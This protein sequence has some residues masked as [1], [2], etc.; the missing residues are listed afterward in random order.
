MNLPTRLP[1]FPLGSVLLPGA[2]MPL[3]IFE[4]RYRVLM[5]DRSGQDPIF[6]VVL[7]E[8]GHEVGDRPTI[9]TV[10]TAATLLAGNEFPDGRWAILIEGGRRFR[11]LGS[12]WERSYLVGSIEWLADE[13]RDVSIPPTAAGQLIG[14]F[15]SY[16]R[17][18][19]E[20]L[21]DPSSIEAIEDGL[22][23]TFQ[24]DVDG[25]TYLVAS[26]LPLNTW[27]RQR[28]L[29]LPSRSD[30]HREARAMIRRECVLL[31]R[32][33]ATTGLTGR[34][35]GSILPNRRSSGRRG[36]PGQRSRPRP[37]SGRRCR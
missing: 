24:D 1:I 35:S 29:E 11:V 34:P 12:S 19:G 16:L 21:A 9:H 17:A 7:T 10:G 31:E 37:T 28:F 27:G 2:Q 23:S 22:R 18:V 5:R 8:T 3:H 4:E 32:S 33:G 6:G 14:D 20:E 30:R 25:L 15:V 26:Q 36:S 13:S